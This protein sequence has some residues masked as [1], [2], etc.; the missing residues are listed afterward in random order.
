MKVS[1]KVS[2]IKLCCFNLNYEGQI[3]MFKQIVF[4]MHIIINYFHFMQRAFDWSIATRSSS[5]FFLWRFFPIISQ[6][7][8]INLGFDTHVIFF[9]I[10]KD[11]IKHA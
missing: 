3:L 5:T 2:E 9:A 8:T 4:N 11:I 6:F 7:F 1:N 10:V